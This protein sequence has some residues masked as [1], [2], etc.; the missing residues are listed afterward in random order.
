[1]EHCSWR[2]PVTATRGGRLVTC[3]S[4]ARG[5]R[6]GRWGRALTERDMETSGRAEEDSGLL[7]T[8]ARARGKRAPSHARRRET[9]VLEPARKPRDPPHLPREVDK[10]GVFKGR[11]HQ[12]AGRASAW[13]WSHSTPEGL[14]VEVPC[15][16]EERGGR[17]AG[18]AE[19]VACAELCVPSFLGLSTGRGGTGTG[20]LSAAPAPAGT[21]GG[22]RPATRRS[23]L[24]SRC[25]HRLAG[26]P[27]QAA[28]VFSLL[29]VS[30]A[31]G[32]VPFCPV[33]L[34][35]AEGLAAGQATGPGSCSPPVSSALSGH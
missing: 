26:C 4:H 12:E 34:G 27:R 20:P 18:W 31:R 13:L 1:M 35:W 16:E 30:K 24:C 19:G 17:R 32:C 29:P 25:R 2:C 9:G 21:V 28:V 8:H 14:L 7:E 22:A 11:G 6:G 10:L 33:G 5:R 3:C 23:G 15:V